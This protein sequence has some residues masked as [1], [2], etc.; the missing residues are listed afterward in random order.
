MKHKPDDSDPSSSYKY[1][2]MCQGGDQNE[3]KGCGHFE[4]LDMTGRA[5][6]TTSS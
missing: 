3:G 6:S 4:Y 1:F 2:W 5:T